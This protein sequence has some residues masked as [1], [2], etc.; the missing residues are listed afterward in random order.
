MRTANPV[1]RSLEKREDSF[2]IGESASYTG[3]IIKT[4]LLL[5]FAVL[6]G[7]VALTYFV[8]NLIPLLITAA[9][10]AFVA[11]LVASFVPRLA[12]PF[13]IIYALAEGVI[14]G[15][16][17]VIFD[18]MYEGIA[19]T[20]VIGTMTIFIVMLFLYSSSIIRVTTRMRRIMTSLLLGFLVF[21]VIFGILRLFGV[22][23]QYVAFDSNIALGITGIFIIYGAFML[24]LDFDNATR[25]VEGQADRSY[26]WVVALGLMVTIVWIYIELLRFLA[27]LSSRRN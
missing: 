18:A 17:T 2:A 16:I 24:T 3:I 22:Y 9:I 7:Y 4:G 21:F 15:T 1:F 5:L 23:D 14:L 10:T 25:I 19:L 12:M 27:I 26:E 11:V 8:D 20:A 13:S 6:S